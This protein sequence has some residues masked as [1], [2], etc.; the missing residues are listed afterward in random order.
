MR[1]ATAN[2]LDLF[3]YYYFCDSLFSRM[4]NIYIFT[5]AQSKAQRCVQRTFLLRGVQFHLAPWRHVPLAKQAL[6][7]PP[8]C[9][10]DNES[11]F[12]FE[13]TKNQK[14]SP[15]ICTSKVDKHSPFH[16]YAMQDLLSCEVN[17]GFG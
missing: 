5:L 16:H 3:T 4:T 17:E 6:S 8:I 14:N 13:K 15:S 1:F 12:F 11:N 9:D 7:F 2:D 10:N